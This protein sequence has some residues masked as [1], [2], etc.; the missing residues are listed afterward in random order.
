[1][2]V[3]V[4]FQPLCVEGKLSISLKYARIHSR[5]DKHWYR[6]DQRHPIREQ[7]NFIYSML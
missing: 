1:M 2:S 7:E 5:M 4:Q 3:T 6:R